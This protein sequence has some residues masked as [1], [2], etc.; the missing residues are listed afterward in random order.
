[1]SDQH[2]PDLPTL[3]PPSEVCRRLGIGT[4]KFNQLVASGD[5]AV[6]RLGGTRRVK[7]DDLARFVEGLRRLNEY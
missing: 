4:S 2:E 7:A 1:M 3:L 6:V 5:L